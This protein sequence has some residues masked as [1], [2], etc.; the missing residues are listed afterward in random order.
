[1][2]STETLGTFPVL[3]YITVL[4]ISCWLPDL[5]CPFFI[6]SPTAT[7]SVQSQI[8]P[9]VNYS[10]SCLY[11]LPP[12]SSMHFNNL[13]IS[14][15][16]NI[17]FALF[18]RYVNSSLSLFSQTGV[19]YTLHWANRHLNSKDTHGTQL[20]SVRVFVTV[21]LLFRICGRKYC[22]Y[23]KIILT[24]EIKCKMGIYLK[25]SINSR[26]TLG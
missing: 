17:W 6:T 24:C 7:A 21:C 8:T 20:L 5:L 25:V 14:W 19:L 15:I 3:A 9:F 18:F 22:Y 26:F 4:T 12:I 23:M 11:P 10:N 2:Q 13:V 1:M 16:L